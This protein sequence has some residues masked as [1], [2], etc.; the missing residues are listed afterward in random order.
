MHTIGDITYVALAGEIARPNAAEHFAAHV[1]MEVA[2]TVDF[3]ARLA[4]E[5]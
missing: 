4:A 1:L 2:H 5:G 3:L